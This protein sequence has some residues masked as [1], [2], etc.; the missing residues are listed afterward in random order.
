MMEERSRF[1]VKFFTEWVMKRNRLCR[2]EFPVPGRP[3]GQA[4][5]KWG[6]PDLLLHLVVS[7]LAHVQVLQLNILKVLPI[8]VIQ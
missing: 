7:N 5:W 6:Q 1:E 3:Q 8:Q 4:G 2:E